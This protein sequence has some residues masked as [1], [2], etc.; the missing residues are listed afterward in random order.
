MPLVTKT[1]V[2]PV[3]VQI[4]YQQDHVDAEAQFVATCIG[5]KIRKMLNQQ[6]SVIKWY[7]DKP[8]ET[9]FKL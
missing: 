9:D 4:E 2:I 6:T 3:I 5:D 1:F 8:K 7:V